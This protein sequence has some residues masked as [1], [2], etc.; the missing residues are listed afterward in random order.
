MP[1]GAVASHCCL[2]SFKS[3]A[4]HLFPKSQVSCCPHLF[5]PM[6]HEARANTWLVQGIIFT[7]FSA[8]VLWNVLTTYCKACA[9]HGTAACYAISLS[10]CQRGLHE[11]NAWQEVKG[12][13][14]MLCK[15]EWWHSSIKC[16]CTTLWLSV[17][18]KTDMHLF[19]PFGSDD[20]SLMYSGYF[21][22]WY[23]SLPVVDSDRTGRWHWMIIVFGVYSMGCSALQYVSLQCSTHQRHLLT[24]WVYQCITIL[25]NNSHL[26]HHSFIKLLIDLV[27]LSNLVSLG[28]YYGLWLTMLHHTNRDTTNTA[29]DTME[30][31]AKF[32]KTFWHAT[33]TI[34]LFDGLGPASEM[35]L[36]TTQWASPSC[37]M[38]PLWIAWWKSRG[39]S[40]LTS[41]CQAV[42]LCLSRGKQSKR[43]SW[44]LVSLGF[45]HGWWCVWNG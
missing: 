1:P 28:R 11:G 18:G 20:L 15:L 35:P 43:N 45:I 40:W 21:Y 32:T 3:A 13:V 8:L 22:S 14:W 9:I 27:S 34:A 4:Q 24:S 38:F 41:H 2:C 16:P 44:H 29:F 25:Y 36:L 37:S 7:L 31:R 12:W 19:E 33:N 42:G 10:C 30:Q 39:G 6:F 26:F 23:T 5:F 17:G